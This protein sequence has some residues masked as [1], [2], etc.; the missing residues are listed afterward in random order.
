MTTVP[1]VCTAGNTKGAPTHDKLFIDAMN[2]GTIRNT[3]PKEIMIGN[4]CTLGA[5]KHTPLYSCLQ[6]PAERELPHSTSRLILE[7]EVMCCPSVYFDIFIQTRSA[8]LACPLAW[9]MS[10]PNSLLITDPIYP[11]M[12]H[13]VVPSLG[14]Q[15][16]LVLDLTG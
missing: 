2:Y 15:A 7:L 16:T 8:Q 6:V 13:S 11:Y 3:H 12:A 5:M 1:T 10:A 14:S 9:I 4:I